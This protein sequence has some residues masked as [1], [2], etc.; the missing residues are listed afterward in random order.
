MH[1]TPSSRLALLLC[2]SVLTGCATYRSATVVQD[3]PGLSFNPDEIASFRQNQDKV[4]EELY[5]LAAVDK[6]DGK[7]TVVGGNWDAV[8][9]AG[10]DYADVRCEA[11]IHALFRLNRDKKSVTNQLGLLGGASAGL[12]AAVDAAARNVAAV[13]I[14]FGLASST[15][16]NLASNLLFELDP[17]SVRTLV[18]SL[19]SHYRAAKGNGYASRPV[20][21][22]VM[23]GYAALCIPANIEAE[24]NVAV[25][26]SSPMS[27]PGNAE[28]G[29]APVVSNAESA[30]TAVKFDDNTAKLRNF[31]FPG[32]TLNADNLARLK[33]FL[34][35]KNLPVDVSSFMRLDRFAAQRAEAAAELGL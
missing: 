17:S 16:D 6:A 18:K 35:A 20:A 8:I 11:Y 19:Q 21:M 34:K 23:R 25:K 26:S 30:I 15:V 32:K 10:M 2:L 33:A 1:H 29:E 4:L 24:V 12:M 27:T 31:V 22:S 3:G 13:A 14:G 7:S 28:T 9:D 5:A